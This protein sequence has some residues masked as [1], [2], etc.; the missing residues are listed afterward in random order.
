M[1]TNI[2]TIYIYF[3]HTLAGVV[4]TSFTLQG[5]VHAYGMVHLHFVLTHHTFGIGLHLVGGCAP[6]PL[7]LIIIFY[8]FCF[9]FYF[10]LF[11]ALL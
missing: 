7:L 6:K 2:F 10:H 8:L 1:L 5:Y 9:V 11:A 3:S 4:T